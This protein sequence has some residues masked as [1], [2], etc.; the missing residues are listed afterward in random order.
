MPLLGP[1]EP[2][3]KAV[4]KRKLVPPYNVDSVMTQGAEENDIRRAVGTSCAPGDYV[5]PVE[6][7]PPTT[8]FAFIF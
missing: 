6:Y 3:L 1:P 4:Q 5:V 8:R 7:T 2:A